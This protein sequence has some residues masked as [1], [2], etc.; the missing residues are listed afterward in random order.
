MINKL[1]LLLFLSFCC[2]KEKI[3][4][5]GISKNT[6]EREH[7]FLKYISFTE[8]NASLPVNFDLY[9]FKS[10]DADKDSIYLKK[11][12]YKKGVHSKTIVLKSLA[13]KTANV[14]FLNLIAKENS[15]NNKTLG[16]FGDA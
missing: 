4:N 9:N 14:E 12:T 15:L 8:Y 16:Q 3:S 10:I 13:N 7:A 11:H 1:I 5:S 6:S 2:C